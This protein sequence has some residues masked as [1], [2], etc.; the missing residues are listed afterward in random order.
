MTNHH[1]KHKDTGHPADSTNSSDNAELVV[2]EQAVNIAAEAIVKGDTKE[3][4]ISAASILA[5]VTR[6]RQMQALHERHPQYGF[7]QHKGY[8]T[9]LHKAALKKFGPSPIHRYSYQ[10]VREAV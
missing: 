6:D 2:E 5:K 7:A 9:R 10:P 8:G 4:A 1:S 3:P